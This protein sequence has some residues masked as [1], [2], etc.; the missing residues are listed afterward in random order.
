M[1]K[2]TKRSIAEIEEEMIGDVKK[3][4]KY[5]ELKTAIMENARK[6]KK[7]EIGDHHF[8]S[9]IYDS[10]DEFIKHHKT[11]LQEYLKTIKD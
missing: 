3:S 5:R 2:K 7:N 8:E 4:Q 9:S 6:W 10:I 11:R 1:E